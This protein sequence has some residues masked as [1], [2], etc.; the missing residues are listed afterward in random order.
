MRQDNPGSTARPRTRI[1]QKNVSAI[2]EAALDVFSRHGF[3]G[4]TLDQIAERADLSK[5]NLLYYF[6]SKEAIHIAL[7]GEL[8]ETWLAP[9]RALDPEGDPVDEIV[10]YVKR[11]LQMARALPRESRLFANEIIQGAP[12]ILDIVEGAL[13]DLVNEKA[14]LIRRWAAEGRI[15]TVDPHHL[16]FSIWATTQ[17][18]ADFDVQVRAV[19]GTDGNSHF[20]DA[21]RFLEHLYRRALTA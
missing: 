18:Y 9:L 6:E 21:E 10:G 20:E 12:R 3:R 5:P 14:A 17:H 13:R 19:L 16:I 2:F 1:Q 7:L 11:K 15:A 8:L 4:S